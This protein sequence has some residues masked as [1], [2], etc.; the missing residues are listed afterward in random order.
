MDDFLGKYVTYIY[1]Q[2]NRKLQNKNNGRKRKSY[3][4]FKDELVLRLL[5]GP[6]AQKQKESLKINLTEGA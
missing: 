5:R 2:S 1:P 6:R 3:L 4:T